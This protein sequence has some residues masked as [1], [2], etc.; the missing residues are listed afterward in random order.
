MPKPIKK[1]KEV[2][3]VKAKVKK[4][5]PEVKEEVV[6]EEAKPVPPKPPVPR[7]GTI[8]PTGGEN[9][10]R[11]GPMNHMN[12]RQRPGRAAGRKR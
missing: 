3:E 4:E 5:A 6:A 9:Q 12:N 10:F 8:R 2:K 7:F 11:S 1:E